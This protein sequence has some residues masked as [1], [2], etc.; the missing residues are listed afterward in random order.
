MVDKKGWKD[1]GVWDDVF[2]VIEVVWVGFVDGFKII[3]DKYLKLVKSYNVVY[4]GIFGMGN[5][6][7]EVCF[8]E[9]DWVWFMFYFGF[10]GVGN[11][12]GWYFIEFVKKDMEKWF[13]NLLDINLVYFLEGIDYFDDYV[14]VVGWV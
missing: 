9:E 13:I 10:W 7:V 14:E 4:L 1:K 3:I 12:I 2:K 11:V 5:Y 8:D 6:F